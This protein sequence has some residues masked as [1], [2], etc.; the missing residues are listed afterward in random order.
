[1]AKWVRFL[2]ASSSGFYA[3]KSGKVAR[4]IKDNEEK[5]LIKNIFCEDNGYGPDRICGIIRK[6]G[7]HMGRIKASRHMSEM[8][9]SSVHN[10]KK[11]RS[12]T[13]SKKARGEGYPNVLRYEY[14]PII[15]RM[16]L[17]SDITYL[18]SDEGFAYLCTV[19]D[20]VTGEILGHHTSDR[21]TKELVVNAFL[22]VVG[23][24]RLESGCIFHSDRGCQYTSKEFMAL[25]VMYGLR[26]SFSRVGMPGDNAWS[27]SFFANMKKELFHW[28]HYSTRDQIRAAVFEYIE[29]RYNRRRVQKRLGYLSP[30]EYYEGLQI[31]EL[32]RVA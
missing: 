27:E 15:P 22:S 28:E 18:R 11:C 31:D 16:A 19:K 9:L 3:W 25:L 21:M 26:Q 8:G 4:E 2:Q 5:R 13:N 1:M 6:R 7:G 29:V 30:S 32:S 20:I 24:H 12:L 23:R 14:F 17:S 10:R